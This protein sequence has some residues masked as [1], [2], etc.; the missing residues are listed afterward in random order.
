MLLRVSFLSIKEPYKA[1]HRNAAAGFRY[2][3]FN[4]RKSEHCNA[5]A[6]LIIWLLDPRKAEYYNAAAVFFLTIKS[7]R[8]TITM[9][10]L[11]FDL[12]Y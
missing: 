1:K 7:L 10:L 3:L 12:D 2:W 9:L 4:H 5:A 6:G 8:Q 11:V